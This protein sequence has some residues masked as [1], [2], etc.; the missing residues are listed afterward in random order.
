[1]GASE[2]ELKK[3]TIIGLYDTRPQ[4]LWVAHASLVHAEFGSKDVEP[5]PIADNPILSRLL[6]LNQQRAG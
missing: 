4:W 2:S 3:R 6:A 5:T 1:M